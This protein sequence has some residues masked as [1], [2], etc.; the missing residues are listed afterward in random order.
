MVWIDKQ[1]WKLKYWGFKLKCEE[2]QFCEMW[3]EKTEC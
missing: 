1:T 2:K 3:N